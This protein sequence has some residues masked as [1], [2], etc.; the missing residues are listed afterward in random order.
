M[1]IFRKKTVQDVNNEVRQLAFT[2]LNTV[3]SDMLYNWA[4]LA[5]SGVGR[6]LSDYR[7]HKEISALEEAEKGIYQVMAA[8]DVLR[9]RHV[10]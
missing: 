7:R 5:G 6:A 8:I 1:N 2:R 3:D 10:E 9:N 4:D